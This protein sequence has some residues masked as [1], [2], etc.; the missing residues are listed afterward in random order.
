MAPFPSILSFYGPESSIDA[1]KE[2]RS[3]IPTQPGDGFTAAEME[4]ALHPTLKPWKPRQEYDEIDIGS[5]IP[6]TKAITFTGRVANFFE[7]QT[8]SKMP[9]AAKG[10]IKVVVGDE[11]GALT[12]RLWY[13]NVNYNLHLGQLV[14]IWTTHISAGEMSTFSTPTAPLVTSIFPERD[15][16]CYFMIHDNSDDGVQCKTPL[17]YRDG[18][19][20]PGLMT[21]RNFIDGGFDIIQGKI[22]VCVKSIGA[23]K[24]YVNKKGRECGLVN[25][26]LFDDTAEA[27][28]T[29]WNT[30]ALSA[31][32]W[33][34]SDTVLLISSPGWKVDKNAH[35]SLNSNTHVD[36]DPCMADADWL[37]GFAQ[38]L[39][40]REH[41]NQ[42]F[43]E[44]V[45]D[46][47]AATTSEVRILFTIADVDEFARA[48]PGEIFMGY[49]SVI[50]TEFQIVL[51]HQRSMMMCTECCGVPLFAN[52]IAAKCKQCGQEVALAINPKIVGSIIDETGC[53]SAG[54]LVWSD[55]AWEQLLGRTAQQLVEA[56]PPLLKY[57]E[58]RLLF[59]RYTLVFGWSED[60]GKLAILQVKM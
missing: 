32:R 46:V 14:S 57:L 58:H 59:L 45:F 20:L 41:V 15:N 7:Q 52:T 2:V 33:K 9:N 12:I 8:Q 4:E 50:I 54:K 11:S 5:L 39:M 30:A 51:L 37:R 42:P 43:P 34:P 31:S 18:Q 6:G 35:L 56:T 17:G 48:A 22:L 23:G 1:S 55:E 19:E 21:L 27:S 26:S 40:K 53:I 24:K 10:F 49:L 13:A 36:V 44:G 29:L 28:L 47:E 3:S 38:R 25:I 16:S 60:V